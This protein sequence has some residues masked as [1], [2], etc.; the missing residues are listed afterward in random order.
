M[1]KKYIVTL[2]D[3]ECQQLRSLI[4]TG[5]TQAY[6]IKHANVLLKA[7]GREG[8]TDQRIAEAFGCSVR[9][10]EN[11]RQR[12]VTQGLEAALDRKKRETPPT[13]PIL[14]GAKQARLTAL[15]C[16]EPPEGRSRWTLQLLADELIRLEIVES[17]S[18]ETV[19]RSLKK[20]S[21]SHTARRAG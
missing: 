19:R 20:T 13:E 12:F 1:A 17:I 11:I 5:K 14:D 3:E 4:D 16:S 6:R 7:D 8:W 10:V 2:T 9:T 15:A 21:F 18:D